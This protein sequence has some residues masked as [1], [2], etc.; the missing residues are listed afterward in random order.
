[1]LHFSLFVGGAKVVSPT[2]TISFTELINVY[3]SNETKTL[4]SQLRS[5]TD[6]I[7]KKEL[8]NKQTFFTPYGVFSYRNN[9]KITSHNS[10]LIAFD[11]DNLQPHQAKDL[12]QKFMQ[13]DCCLFTSI[14]GSLKGVKAMIIINNTIAYKDRYTTLKHNSIKLL[15][16]LNLLQYKDYLDLRQFVLSQP[17]YISYDTEL[18]HNNNCTPITFDF[19]I[20]AVVETIAPIK[21]I[22][23]NATDKTNL[24]KYV[25]KATNNLID[26]YN[27]HKGARHSEIARAKGIAGLIKGY[28][29]HEIENDV[30]SSIENAVIRMYGTYEDAIKG[31]AI[32]SLKKAW[33]DATEINNDAMNKIIEEN[34]NETLYYKQYAKISDKQIK[35]LDTKENVYFLPISKIIE[36]TENYITA[37]KWVFK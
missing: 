15:E 35:V 23:L 18:Y 10:N 29:L 25:E 27:N 3:K 11:F 22:S 13:L 28:D 7:L 31:N 12:K 32:V 17:M 8:K 26:F 37:P 34:K 19:D 5:C 2:K 14:S 36:I 24:C 20:P 6:E 1:M 33:N 30:Y 16:V 21:N 9:E 4:S